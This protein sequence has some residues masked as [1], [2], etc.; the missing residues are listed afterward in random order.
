M[1]AAVL[2]LFGLAALAPAVSSLN[3]LSDALSTHWPSFTH[4]RATF[5]AGAVAIV[6]MATMQVDRLGPIFIGIGAVF[7]P[8]LGAMAGD[9]TGK[10]ESGLRLRR[11]INLAGVC[12]WTAGVAVAVGSVVM[13]AIQPETSS[14]LQAGSIYGFVVSACL[15]R[16]L[17]RVG[18]ESADSH[19][20]LAKI[21][22]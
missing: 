2:I 7:L 16:V 13:A 22:E 1:V 19:V 20:S 12:A 21:E 18:L 5:L 14:W 17:A 10:T 3:K 11:G 6:L 15:Y 9:L 4:R 8:A